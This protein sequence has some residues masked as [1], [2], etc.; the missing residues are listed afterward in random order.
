MLKS[1]QLV[2][3]HVYKFALFR[4]ALSTST[5]ADT[6]HRSIIALSELVC[7]SCGLHVMCFMYAASVKHRNWADH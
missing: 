1:R 4:S 3:P 7:H 6:E 2:M 5:D